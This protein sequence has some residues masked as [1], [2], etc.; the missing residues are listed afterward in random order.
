ME[1]DDQLD[2]F[3]EAA[4]AGSAGAEEVPI[5]DY[6]PITSLSSS[7]IIYES[8]D[9]EWDDHW[10]HSATD[11]YEGKFK[12][13]E[14][15]H[16]EGVRGDVQLTMPELAKR[17]GLFQRFGA[18]VEFSGEA[19]VPALVVQYEVQLQEGLSCGGAY[20]K[21][22]S[23]GEVADEFDGTELDGETPYSIM[24]GPDKCGTESKV[25]FI[26]RHKN[27]KTGVWEEKHMTDRPL[28]RV[29]EAT[30]AY[31]LVVRSDNSFE[32]LID[33]ESVR[34]GSLLSSDDFDPPMQ[35]PEVIDDPTDSKP[36]DWVDAETIDDPEAERPAWADAE[37]FIADPD[38]VKPDGWLDDGPEMVPDPEAEMPA[39]WDEEEDGEWVAPLVPNPVCDEVGCGHWAP[40]QISNPEYQ[41]KYTPPQIPNP[42]YKGPWKARQIPNPAYYG[43]VSDA[44]TELAP[45]HGLAFELWTMSP[46]I[47]FDNVLVSTSEADAATARSLGWRPKYDRHAELIRRELE[48]RKPKFTD[49]ASDAM[50][51]LLTIGLANPLLGLAVALGIVLLPL[52]LCCLCCAGSET[53]EYVV[54]EYS[55]DEADD[56]DDDGSDA[57][58]LPKASGSVSRRARRKD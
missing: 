42:A 20:V 16:L 7:V 3:D 30:H 25:H 31:T 43:V 39:D 52:L 26:F 41:G 24:F 19:A 17:Y 1:G 6:K 9:G 53:Q 57:E 11:G 36:A 48:K 21:L 45:I 55:D 33:G 54:E 14:A 40:R 15:L 51:Y 44:F 18:P 47:A 35:L 29:D 4:G 28:V 56:D 50:N 32:L 22:I 38:D 34:S 46:G 13:L 23:A 8:F 37:P 27:P 12:V 10:I 58:P 49:Q 2:E 5:D